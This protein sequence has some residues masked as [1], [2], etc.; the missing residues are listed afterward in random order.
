MTSDEALPTLRSM[1]E[2]AGIRLK[3]PDAVAVYR[4]FKDFARQPVE[5]VVD[6]VLYQVGVYA[7]GEP[8]TFMIHLV[9][10]FSFYE[11]GEYD[12]MEQL[13][14]IIH[15]EP[16]G[17]LRSLG[18]FNAWADSFATLDEF[19]RAMDARPEWNLVRL[20]RPTRLRLEQGQV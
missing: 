20:K 18:S 10:Q 6:G 9:R 13:H 5:G 12:R 2:A 3:A 17:D 16:D 4:V 8:E 11:D 15:Y 19:F 14:C 7:F 1:L